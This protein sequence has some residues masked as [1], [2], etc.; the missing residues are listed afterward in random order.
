MPYPGEEWRLT[1]EFFSKGLIDI[2]SLT[3]SSL[4]PEGY[5]DEVLQLDGKPSE[6][7]I[8]LNWQN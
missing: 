4:G 6:G 5:M 3:Q 7:K 1:A 2:E 8:L